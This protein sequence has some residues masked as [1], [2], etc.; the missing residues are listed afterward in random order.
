MHMVLLSFRLITHERYNKLRNIL[1][2]TIRK[3]IK[4]I[5]TPQTV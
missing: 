2:V 4:N 3:H 5:K 1:F